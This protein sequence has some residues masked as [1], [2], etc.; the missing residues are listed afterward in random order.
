MLWTAQWP[1]FNNIVDDA[2]LVKY[3]FDHLKVVEELLLGHWDSKKYLVDLW[4]TRRALLVLMT[5]SNYIFIELYLRIC[6][7]I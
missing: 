3:T 6:S 4:Q 5:G 2:A 7:I 1:A